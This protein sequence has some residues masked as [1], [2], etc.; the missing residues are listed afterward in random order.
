MADCVTAACEEPQGVERD[1]A[2]GCSNPNFDAELTCRTGAVARRAGT[3]SGNFAFLRPEAARSL[4]NSAGGTRRI[5]LPVSAARRT[6]WRTR[7]SRVAAGPSAPDW[8]RH[9]RNERPVLDGPNPSARVREGVLPAP[10]KWEWRRI[11]GSQGLARTPPSPPRS[12]VCSMHQSD[13]NTSTF[14]QPESE[15]LK[16]HVA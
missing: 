13:A 9:S 14:A 2:R 11:A 7:R 15:Y 5:A 6:Q 16:T 8:H 4:R 1:R 3:Q 12:G 10:P